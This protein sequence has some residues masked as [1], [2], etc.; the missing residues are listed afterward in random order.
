M[1]IVEPYNTVLCESSLIEHNDVC[2]LL[3]NE[4]LY[5]ICTRHLDIERC[6]YTNLNRIIA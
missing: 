4:A 2:T 5:H 1:S 6:S 3:D